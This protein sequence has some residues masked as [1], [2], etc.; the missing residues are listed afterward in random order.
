MGLMIKFIRHKGSA[1][2]IQ[3]IHILK[4]HTH[5]VN[6]PFSGTTQVSRSLPEIKKVTR[7]EKI[8]LYIL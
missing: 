7:R 1:S 4:T 5:P 8:P 2:T 3:S 6:G